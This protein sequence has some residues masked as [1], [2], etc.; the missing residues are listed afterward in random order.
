MPARSPVNGPGPAPQTIA[1][2]SARVCPAASS[3]ARTCGVSNSP[4]ALASTV[5]RSASTSRRAPSTATTPAV[6]A[7]VA[8]STARTSTAVKP[9]ATSGAPA[10]DPLPQV[11]Q[12]LDHRVRCHVDRH[13]LV[14]GNVAV[15]HQ[16]GAHADALGAADVVVGPVADVDALGR[17]VDADGGHRGAEGRRVRLGVLEV[18]APDAGVEQVEHAVACENLLVPRG[19]PR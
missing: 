10:V 2:T 15:R 11:G 7:G 19:G 12:P 17:V 4:C 14:D 5:T 9:T 3:A 1:S 6:T 8:V 16:N 18:A 13:P